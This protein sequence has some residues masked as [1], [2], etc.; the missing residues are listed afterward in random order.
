MPEDIRRNVTPLANLGLGRLTKSES[1]I[2]ISGGEQLQQEVVRA[3]AVESLAT[4]LGSLGPEAFNPA[5]FE[6]GLVIKW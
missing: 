6:F 3:R 4:T 1:T 5:A 2:K